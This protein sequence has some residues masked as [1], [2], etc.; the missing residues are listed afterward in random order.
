MQKKQNKSPTDHKYLRA[1]AAHHNGMENLAL[2]AVAMV[3]GNLSGLPASQLNMLGLG[4]LVS[5]SLY[6]IL[7]ISSSDSVWWSRTVAHYTGMAII[8]RIFYTSARILQ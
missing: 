5:R 4:Y 8:T 6:N 7:Y 1:Q 3:L 2:Y